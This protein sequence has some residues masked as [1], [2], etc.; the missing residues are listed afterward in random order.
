MRLAVVERALDP[1]VAIV[2]VVLGVLRAR[3]PAQYGGRSCVALV[4]GA[5]DVLGDGFDSS[6]SERLKFSSS[7]PAGQVAVAHAIGVGSALVERALEHAPS[8]IAANA[9]TER[10]WPRDS[11]ARWPAC[12]GSWSSA[13]QLIHLVD[14]ALQVVKLLGRWARRPCRP[15]RMVMTCG[16]LP[17]SSAAISE[18][19]DCICRA[20]R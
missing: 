7:T 6:G 1:R 15:E 4:P 3:C 20:S 2:D 16:I 8:S 18:A 11:T 14:E 10:R 19:F 5:A 9:L 17:P 13:T 12:R